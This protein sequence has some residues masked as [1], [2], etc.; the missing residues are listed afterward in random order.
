MLTFR[1]TANDLPIAKF[2][3]QTEQEWLEILASG[4]ASGSKGNDWTPEPL[5]KEQ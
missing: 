1:L 4:K 5:K 3:Q 2:C